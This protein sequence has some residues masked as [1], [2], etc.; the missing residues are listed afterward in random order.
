MGDNRHSLFS[1][2]EFRICIADAFMRDLDVNLV[3]QCNLW[4]KF[5]PNAR[6][7]LPTKIDYSSIFQ[8]A[9]DLD[10]YFQHDRIILDMPQGM[11]FTPFGMLFLAT[12]IRYFREK[13]PHC[14]LI[15][16]GWNGYSYLS[17]MGFFNLCGF[18]YGKEMGAAWG[19]INYIPITEVT[20]TGLYEEPADRWEELPDLIQR[21][22]DRAAEVL[23]RDKEKNKNLFDILSYS[24]REIFRNVFEHAE[25]DRLFFCAQYWP[26]S[27]K[28]EFSVSDFGVGIRRGLSA[29]PNFRFTSDKEAIEFSLM[30]SVSGKTHLPRTSATWF[31]SGYGLYMT[32]RL[33][34][35]G[36][37][38][39]VAS[40]SDA[41]FLSP[42]T[43]A[44][45]KTSF[46]GTILKVN[47]SI[48]NIGSVQE[49]LAQ[50]R[51]EGAEEAK[52]ISGSG[53]RP[54]SAMSLLLRRDFQKN[55]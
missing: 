39:L 48:E 38:F 10:Y 54:P 45:F 23:A 25:A 6:I 50:Y 30:P 35:N 4:R 33:A 40:G 22:A 20:R 16:N 17:H 1:W 26:K 28:V 43:K 41:V 7:T 11:N 2:T 47:F 15:F 53:N 27:K 36:G 5:L 52:N 55:R 32:N 19:S 24:I 8:F 51:K 13:A 34:R 31:N 9:I 49:K 46:K 12:K 44:N 18:D 3:T 42:K 37:N 21:S 14:E 29:N